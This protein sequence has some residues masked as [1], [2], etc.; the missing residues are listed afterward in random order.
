MGVDT[1]NMTDPRPLSADLP[2]PGH[3]ITPEC[4]PICWTTG[5]H[6]DPEACDGCRRLADMMHAAGAGVRPTDPRPLPDDTAAEWYRRGWEAGNKAATP[7]PL[8]VDRLARALLTSAP[9]PQKKPIDSDDI[10]AMRGRAAAI[11]AAYAEEA[12]S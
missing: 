9:N 10:A 4:G 8:D 2:I 11:A 6:H 3:T 12:E 1:R 7:A 5:H